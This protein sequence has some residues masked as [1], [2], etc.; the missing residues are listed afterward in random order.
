M[1]NYELT[2]KDKDRFLGAGET[3]IITTVKN[4]GLPYADTPTNGNL[5]AGSNTIEI[6]L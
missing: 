5:F 3:G 1:I 2:C 4:R 6:E